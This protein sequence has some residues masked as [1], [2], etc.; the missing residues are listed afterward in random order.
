MRQIM[1]ALLLAAAMIVLPQRVPALSGEPGDS[2]CAHRYHTGVQT[3][4]YDYD[5]DV[6]FNVYTYPRGMTD[7]A[8]EPGERILQHVF[9]GR[10]ENWTI[11]EVSGTSGM[12]VQEH[13][14]VSSSRHDCMASMIVVTDRR[15]YHLTLCG[16][17]DAWM[18]R[19]E[20]NY[21]LR[22]DDE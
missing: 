12:N 8:F 13:L 21:P 19:V 18:D 1:T 20:W 17:A 10:N 22:S 6:V 9:A 5:Q 15:T 14:F 4:Q 3:M 2:A 11:R 7:V 16:N